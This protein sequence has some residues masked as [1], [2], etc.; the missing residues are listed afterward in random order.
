VILGR[1]RE[2]VFV[3]ITLIGEVII[4]GCT[5]LVISRAR[6]DVAEKLTCIWLAACPMNSMAA[7]GAKPGR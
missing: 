5:T 6:P 3:A 7:N 4:F 1:W 2:S